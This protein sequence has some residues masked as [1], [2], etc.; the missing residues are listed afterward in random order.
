MPDI[1]SY[2]L[3]RL[4]DGMALRGARELV[5]GL[6][7]SEELV[8]YVVDLVR[9]TRQNASIL[10]GGSPRGANMIA[11]ASRALAA[12]RGRTFVIPDD[13]KDLFVPAMRHRV[14]LGPGA[15][16]EGMTPDAVL[17]QVLASV[18]APR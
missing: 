8:D 4:A 2:G 5:A 11:T 1:A 18:K 14:V 12:L 3:R 16:V 15:E 6:R 13:V 17:K 9:A 7:L 10:H